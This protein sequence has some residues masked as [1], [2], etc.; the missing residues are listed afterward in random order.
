MGGS[1]LSTA[2][3]A[4]NLDRGKK[5]DDIIEVVLAGELFEPPRQLRVTARAQAEWGTPE[6]AI[7]SDF[8]A[9]KA[10]DTE[11]ILANYSA[12][13]Q[14]APAEFLDG[15]E[16]RAASR[17]AFAKHDSVF[18]RGVVRHQAYAL[19][20]ITY[21]QGA[22]RARGLVVTLVEEAGGWKRTNA[23]SADATMDIVWTAF[24]VGELA[25]R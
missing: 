3:Q 9:W 20:L 8:S 4:P 19:A 15:A 25:A 13:D 24:R 11:W 21:G 10:D 5:F 14:A 23:L 17:T 2:H 6:A 1:P 12:A 7:R 16:M 22:A 18:L